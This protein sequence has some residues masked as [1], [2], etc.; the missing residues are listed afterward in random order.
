M[1]TIKLIIL[2]CAT[3]MIGLTT[4]AQDASSTKNQEV[5]KTGT[6]EMYY[7]HFSRRCATCQ[8]VEDVSQESVQELYG[9]QVAFLAYNLEE[10]EGEM[11]GEEIGVSG[12][13]LLIVSGDTKIDLTN[14]GFMNARSNPE[15]LKEIIKENIDPLL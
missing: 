15:K 3:A 12:Q 7:F 13:T 1:K 14:E 11:K 5:I 8:A 2:V 4:A 6:V 9:D 10:E